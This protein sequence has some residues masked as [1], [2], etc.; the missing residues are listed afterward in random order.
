MTRS[1]S[2]ATALLLLALSLVACG[3]DDERGTAPAAPAEAGAFP[4]TIEHEYGTTRIERAPE[5]VVTVGLNE[6]DAFFALGIAPVAV[7]DWMGFANGIG[8]WA[9]KAAAAAGAQ[10]QL[11]KNTDGI[12]FEKIAAL[13]PDVIVALYS[14]L[15][16]ADHDKLSQIAPTVAPP[17]GYAD[18]RIPWQDAT[19]TVGRIV[20]K[21][22]EAE[23]LVARV[24]ARLD[25]E[26][27]AHPEFKGKM[28]TMAMPYRGIW[29]YG[30]DDPRSRLLTSLGFELSPAITKLFTHDYSGKISDEQIG[31]LDLDAV[32]WFATEAEARKLQRNRLYTSLAVHND[33]RDAVLLDSRPDKA[34]NAAGFS[35][36]LSIPPTLDVLVPEL[37][38]ALKE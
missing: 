30:P 24:E 13:Q 16:K 29:V 26:A 23:K 3:D 9:E 35:T 7:T 2:A 27:E 11:L 8:P 28:A 12:A 17:K 21:S 15:T 33:K 1:L 18:W 34:Y 10:P 4:V 38:A 6:Q 20:G 31:L 32:V 36:V 14:D 37:A 5:R 19:R 22:A 25:R